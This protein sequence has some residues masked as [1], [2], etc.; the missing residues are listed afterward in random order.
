MISHQL[1][2][3]SV[4]F[5][6]LAV[7]A[8][9]SDL[10]EFKVKREPVFEFTEKPKVTRDG[11]KVTISF[12]SKGYCDATV[13]I[14]NA[15]SR[16]VRHLASG[17]LGVNAPSPFQK[18]ALEQTIVWDGKDD[19]GKYVDDKDALTVRV[20]LGLKPQFE[21]S[22]FW[23]PHKRMSNAC[24]LLAATEEGVF[25]W[26]GRGVDH[27]RLFDH[28]GDYVRT[29]YPFPADKLGKVLGLEKRVFP[30]DGRELPLKR[31]FVQ[32][33]LLTSG[34]SCL[35]GLKYKFGD[36]Y[37]A[38]AM[39]A[40]KGRIALAYDF[41]NRLAT[42]GSTGG[43]KLTGPKVGRRARW[44]GYG[45]H[46]GGEE[47]I[48]PSSMAFSPDG[49]WLYLTGYMWREMYMGGANCLH[50]VLRVA[51]EKDAEPQVFAGVMKG[52]AGP[53]GPS[54]FAGG[55]LPRR[56]LPNGD[57][58]GTDERHFK[59]P[60]SVACDARGRVYVADHMND[61][62]QVFNSDGKLLKS[63]ASKKPA[64]VMVSPKTGEIWV[65]SWP[66]IGI[67]NH[68]LRTTGFQWN[69][70]PTIL[71]QYRSFENPKEVSREPMPIGIGL[72]GF[73]LTGPMVNVAVDWWAE[74][75]TLWVVARK[76]NISRID[77]AWGGVGAYARRTADPWVNDG[78]RLFQ[79]RKDGR[80]VVKR[81]FGRDAQRAVVRVKPPDFGRQRLYVNPKNEKLYV[82][83]DAGFSKSSYEMVEIDP[84]T[85]KIRL[86][87]IPFDAEDICFDL[88][89]RA[90]LRTDTLVVRYDAETWREVPWDY[91]EEHRGVGFTSL[92]GSKRT[93][94]ISALPTPGVRPVCW[95]QGGMNVSPK[96]YLVVSCCSRAAA[97][98]RAKGSSVWDRSRAAIV[99]KPYT[100]E[101][102]PGRVRWQEIHVW[103][104]HG[105]VVCEDAVPG[106]MAMNGIGMDREGDIYVMASP[107][108]VLDKKR[109]WNEMAGTMIK[110]TPTKA[111]V[112]SSS[113]RA[114]VPL[115]KESWP[116]RPF[117]IVNSMLGAAWVKGA[118]WFY[119][120]V[121][122]DGFN[123]SHSGGG[124]DCW[125]S[126]FTLDYFARSF[127]PEIGHFS[128]AVLDTKGN[129]ILRVGTY[130]N[131][132]DGLP[133]GK[134]S[135]NAGKRSSG[136]MPGEPP[137]QRS[138]GG[139]EV[140][141]FHAAYVG[142]HT[143]RRLFIADAGNGRIVSVK[144]G[145]HA[146]EKVAL[147]DVPAAPR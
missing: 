21:R 47:I 124:C 115:A 95:N 3:I 147:K 134:A 97:R 111:R 66:V 14:E 104:T 145:Y 30:Q 90:Y 46:G 98:R 26:E 146:T 138:I 77:V 105:K 38:T 85:G 87:Q 43:L 74:R 10:D 2:V 70:I 113:G 1:S 36:G 141:L 126:R 109:Y 130:G 22:L 48:G 110:L 103:D 96:G 100:P 59:V 72:W 18:N 5:A 88:D 15:D 6:A 114:V 142:T 53:R 86:V 37:A 35:L 55:K 52:D 135:K 79:Q 137:H 63:I 20:S 122:F 49:K 136:F 107:G 42:D 80:W 123:P 106:L 50:G 45:G 83:E 127:A 117:D 27:V 9:A 143:D 61:R 16:I 32:A 23:S 139:D 91:G 92:G 62:V 4:L 19:Q 41:I 94:V 24:P 133:F 54:Q 73:F 56:S 71:R 129:L 12:A 60:S 119:G 57:G 29:V 76:H 8:S 33:S 121:G 99:A 51:Y 140:G 89:G 128:V 102:F 112:T 25:V 31:G 101:I 7:S 131:V 11:D 69:K 39:A 132:D 40:A 84:E 64:K 120:G 116:T 75:P 81:A 67:S 34:T 68:I 144:L 17:V 78:I 13:A 44:R 108:R 28:N 82:M 125:N 65:L 58:C 93:N 118:K